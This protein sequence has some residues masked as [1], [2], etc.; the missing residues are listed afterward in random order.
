[1]NA[2]YKIKFKNNGDVIFVNENNKKD[3]INAN[4]LMR[5]NTRWSN[6]KENYRNV[7]GFFE[8]CN[9]F[10]RFLILNCVCVRTIR[11]SFLICK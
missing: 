1:M 4:E 11:K 5:F 7:E 3:K 9:C 10:L 6:R 8:D 2:T